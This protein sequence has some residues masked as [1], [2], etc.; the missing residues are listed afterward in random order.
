MDNSAAD[1]LGIFDFWWLGLYF[2]FLNMHVT[3]LWKNITDHPF[4]ALLS[5]HFTM[6]VIQQCN[7]YL[8]VRL[9]HDPAYT[10]LNSLR[11]NQNQLYFHITIKHNIIQTTKV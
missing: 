7:R 1:V 5:L 4:K 11:I 3:I 6:K 8:T 10:N 9:V 2:Y